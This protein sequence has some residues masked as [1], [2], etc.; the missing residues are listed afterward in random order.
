MTF[1]GGV[2][3]AE[4]LLVEHGLDPQHHVEVRPEQQG[5]DVAVVILLDFLNLTVVLL[6]FHFAHQAMGTMS[7]VGR[8]RFP[9]VH[10]H[11]AQRP[12]TIA[13]GFVPLRFVDHVVDRVADTV[14]FKLVQNV[15]HHLGAEGLLLWRRLPT[16][17]HLEIGLFQVAL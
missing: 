4:S 13:K 9:A 15:G 11:A 16:K 8:K 6:P 2:D 1:M 12:I 14:Q 7:L 10:R 3:I 5:H 17:Q